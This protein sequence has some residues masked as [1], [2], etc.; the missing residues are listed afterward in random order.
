VSINFLKGLMRREFTGQALKGGDVVDLG[1]GHEL[2]FVMAPNLHWPDSMFSFDRA[3]NIMYTCDAF[4]SH[5]C[6]PDPWDTDVQAVLPHYRFYYDCLMKPN[7]RSVTTALRKVRPGGH[8]VTVCPPHCS[9][10]AARRQ[11]HTHGQV[12]ALWRWRWCSAAPAVWHTVWQRC[13]AQTVWASCVGTWCRAAPAVTRGGAG[14]GLAL[15][16]RC[17]GMAR[18]EC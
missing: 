16:H 9:C 14:A 13:V 3:T 2:E 6:S 10:R 18:S 15:R 7:S 4:G 12:R 5:Y 11:P 8:S 1:G 17:W